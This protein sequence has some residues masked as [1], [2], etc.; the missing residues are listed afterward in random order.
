MARPQPVKALASSSRIFNDQE[1]LNRL[2]A[3]ALE[4]L[5]TLTVDFEILLINDG[6]TDRSGVIADGLARTIKQLRVIHHPNNR[7]Y[8]AALRTGSVTPQRISFSTLMV[9]DS[10]M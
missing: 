3:K 1:T 2:V 9:M 4:I 5:P 8:G 7:G 6:S 10:M